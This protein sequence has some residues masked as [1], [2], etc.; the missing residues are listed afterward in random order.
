MFSLKCIAAQ[1]T[2]FVSKAGKTWF[3]ITVL[4]ED[5]NSYRVF[6]PYSVK[7]NDMV[8]F[9]HRPMTIAGKEYLVAYIH[10]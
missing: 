2:P 6:S 9:S 4:L 10:E 7:V 5:G 8:E 1:T 3:P